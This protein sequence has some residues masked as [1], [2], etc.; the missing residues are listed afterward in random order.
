MTSME[1]G[2]F[3]QFLMVIMITELWGERLTTVSSN[4]QLFVHATYVNA[5]HVLSVTYL[6]SK[7]GLCKLQ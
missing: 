1:N 4:V 7:P 2:V 3:S 6:V 5:T